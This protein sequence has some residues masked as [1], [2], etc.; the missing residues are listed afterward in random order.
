MNQVVIAP[1]I[2]SANFLKLGDE[3]EAIT[4]GG[5]DWIHL[6]MMD[7]HFVPNLSFG[8]PVVRGLA[9]Q[10]LPLDVHLMVEHPEMYFPALEEMRAHSCSVHVEACVH[11]ERTLRQIQSHGMVP[12][13]A[14]NPGTDPEFLRW[15]EHVVG[16]VLIMTVNPG[17]SGQKFIPEMMAKV[18][19]VRELLGPDVR[20]IVDGGIGPETSPMAREAGADVL[21]AA[22]AIFGQSD[23]KA[24]ITA[25]R[26]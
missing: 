9:A 20:I 10:N 14:L 19:R 4:L 25:L 8:P 17:F 26:G 16:H 11:L 24:A 21:V 18:S 12:G 22:S 23:Y 15:V 5:A 6:D 1:S 3:I 7:G 13:V 2:L